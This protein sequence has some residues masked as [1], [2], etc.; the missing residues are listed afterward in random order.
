MQTITNNYFTPQKNPKFYPQIENI[1]YNKSNIQDNIE[2]AFYIKSQGIPIKQLS[3]YC[4]ISMSYSDILSIQIKQKNK[5]LYTFPIEHN[6]NITQIINSYGNNCIIW[7]F[8]GQFYI[9]EFFNNNNDEINNITNHLSNKITD[10]GNIDNLNEFLDNNYTNINFNKSISIFENINNINQ[11]PDKSNFVNSFN[12]YNE[13]YKCTGIAFKYDKYSN[14][15]IPLY[16]E[17]DENAFIK[18][19]D[20]GETYYLLIIEKNEKILVATKIKEES[21]IVINEKLGKMS[22]FDNKQ[23]IITPY[24]VCFEDN[25]TNEINYFKNV[26]NRCLYEA[27]NKLYKYKENENNKD[28]WI[29]KSNSST[30]TAYSKKSYLSYV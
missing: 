7:D 3:D 28:N 26:I 27:Y 16:K 10:F 2:G 6:T 24:N 12:K 4:F 22:F 21:S 19:I 1:N 18:I 23:N 11:Y 13:I 30:S 15:L 25:S 29:T 8:N 9:F 17:I 14:Q 5:F 20:I